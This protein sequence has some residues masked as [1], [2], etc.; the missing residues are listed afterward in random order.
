MIKVYGIPNC[1]SV[2]KARALLESLGVAYEFVDFKKTPPSRE[3]ITHWAQKSSLSTL[4]NTK[5][6]TYKKLD[7]K[8]KNLNDEQKIEAM[9][10][11]PTLIKRPVVESS[12]ESSAM[13]LYTDG[14]FTQILTLSFETNPK[15]LLRAIQ[16]KSKQGQSLYQ[17]YCKAFKE[18]AAWIEALE[19]KSVISTNLYDAFQTALNLFGVREA[20]AVDL[21]TFAKECKFPYV[22]PFGLKLK[23]ESTQ[24]EG[25]SEAMGYNWN[26]AKALSVALA[27]CVGGLDVYGLSYSLAR[28]VVGMFVE[29]A[30]EQD[31]AVVFEGEIFTHFLVI[32]SH[33]AHTTYLVDL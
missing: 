16:S 7:L 10:T 6:T 24:Q 5:G 4:L 33:M 14:A 27:Y 22:S 25:Q 19:G 31:C 23:Q 29:V 30:K 28:E 1:G 21:L 18:N 20:S 9:L 3:Q 12:T 11:H 26:F 2:K 17:N 32:E 8:D 13:Y 15:L